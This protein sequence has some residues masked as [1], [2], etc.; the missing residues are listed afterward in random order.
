VCADLDK[1]FITV[2]AEEIDRVIVC[3]GCISW[4]AADSHSYVDPGRGAHPYRTEWRR[5]QPGGKDDC[6]VHCQNRAASTDAETI[7]FIDGI[8]VTQ[9]RRSSCSGCPA[10]WIPE[11]LA[12]Q[13]Q[14]RSAACYHCG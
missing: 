5:R 3:V 9:Q 6:D 11:Q 7:V 14:N 2:Q 8:T 13:F 4:D 12:E 1:I 10:S